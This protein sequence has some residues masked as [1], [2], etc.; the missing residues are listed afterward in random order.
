MRIRGFDGVRGISALLVVATHLGFASL[1]ERLGLSRLAPLC[2][3]DA[4]VTFFFV[5]SGFLITTLLLGELASSGTISLKHFL[6]RRALRLYPLYYLVLGLV[7]VSGTL[8]FRGTNQTSAAYALLYSY[9]FIPR[10]AYDTWIGA[11]HTLAVEEHFYLVF[12]LSMFL[13]KTRRKL[14]LGLLFSYVLVV[15]SGVPERVVRTLVPTLLDTHFFDRWT[16]VA[17][18]PIALGCLLALAFD[19][20]PKPL[21][22][23]RRAV[24]LAGLTCYSA[25]VFYDHRLLTVAGCTLLTFAIVLN[26]ESRWVRALEAPPLCYLGKVSYGIYVWQAFFLTTGPHAVKGW[27]LPFPAN[28]ALLALTVPLSFR[29][30]EKPCLELKDRIGY[31]GAA[32]G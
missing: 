25:P 24:L 16:P 12:P 32:A 1:L 7:L 11:F 23:F 15:A 3:G 28:L 20:R 14:F 10:A 29:L 9:N 6:I 31:R 19:A 4:A 2:S 13:F 30:I 27:P 22:R 8:G 26:Q 5:L 21:F 17:A 18:L